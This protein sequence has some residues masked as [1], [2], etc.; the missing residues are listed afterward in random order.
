MDPVGSG[1]Q[2]E[3]GLDS[4]LHPTARDGFTLSTQIST[5]FFAST[6]STTAELFDASPG[7]LGSATQDRDLNRLNSAPHLLQIIAAPNTQ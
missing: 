4:S 1:V 2:P 6:L 7:V 3:S 5:F